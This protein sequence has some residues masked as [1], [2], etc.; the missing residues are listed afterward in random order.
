MSGESSLCKIA[1]FSGWKV[2]IHLKIVRECDKLWYNTTKNHII[3]ALFAEYLY[4]INRAKFHLAGCLLLTSMLRHASTEALSN[5]PYT[6]NEV[7]QMSFDV[8][9][10]DDIIW[11]SVHRYHDTR[12]LSSFYNWQYEKWLKAQ[13]TDICTDACQ[14][15][16]V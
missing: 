13:I 14:E 11:I 1:I 3:Q 16:T 15:A 9:S 8:A 2:K 10:F 7:N 12:R 4:V 6:A 5:F